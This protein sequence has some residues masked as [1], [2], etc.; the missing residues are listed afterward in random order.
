MLALSSFGEQGL[1]RF[2]CSGFLF[3]WLLLLQS[4]GSRVLRL[5]E[6]WF[7]GSEYKLNS[8]GSQ[9]QLL[10]GIWDLLRPG[11]EP[12]SLHWQADSITEP[13]EEPDL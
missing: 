8:C 9:A 1:L 13:V 3:W 7:P 6:L 5:Q 4:M 10:H 12:V 2:R 11:I